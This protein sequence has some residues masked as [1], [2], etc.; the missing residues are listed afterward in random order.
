MREE[1]EKEAMEQPTETFTY[2]FRIPLKTKVMVDEL[3][4]ARKKR[5]NQ[6]LQLTVARV[7]HEANFD[8]TRYLGSDIRRGDRE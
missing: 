7:L 8:P 3:T 5:L 6:E 2:S 4:P 1:T